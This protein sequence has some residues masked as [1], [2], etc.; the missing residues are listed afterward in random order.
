MVKITLQALLARLSAAGIRDAA[1]MKDQVTQVSVGVF[2]DQA[3]AVKRAEQV[4]T[5]GF[6]PVLDV[7]QRTETAAWLD[8]DVMG[9]DAD[10]T[11]GALPAAASKAAF[12]DCPTRRGGG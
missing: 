7:H 6:K 4:R 8:V 12:V 11:I 5:L 1:A 10:P 3:H 9:G 2:S